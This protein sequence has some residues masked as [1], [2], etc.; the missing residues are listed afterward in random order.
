[1]F[2]AFEEASCR[3]LGYYYPFKPVW[4][5][6]KLIFFIKNRT[7]KRKTYGRGVRYVP[8]VG[9]SDI[10][11]GNRGGALPKATLRLGRVIAGLS[12]HRTGPFRALRTLVGGL[13][14]GFGGACFG[15]HSGSCYGTCGLRRLRETASSKR[16][17]CF[18]GMKI[19]ANMVT[20][21]QQRKKSLNQLRVAIII[22]TS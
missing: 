1:M 15:A 22:K 16:C 6:K 10:V 2:W 18:L 7:W 14:F 3:V 5:I 19:L 11:A 12:G 9:S 17:R 20:A 8:L 21:R 13:D 4:K